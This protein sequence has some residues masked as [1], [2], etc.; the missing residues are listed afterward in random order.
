FLD[1]FVNAANNGTLQQ[2]EGIAFGPDGNLYVASS[3]NNAVM[4]YNGTTGAPAP[5]GNTP[6]AIYVAIAAGGLSVPKAL[7][8]GP[9]NNLYVASSGSN[10]VIS[11]QGP[12]GGNPGAVVTAPFVAATAPN[13]PVSP[14]GLAFRADG[15][16]LVASANTNDIRLYR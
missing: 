5:S 9:D 6:N 11:Y 2:P 15:S 3:G 14:D 12:A 16:L 10:Q 1:N 4:R 8:F 13:G 7:T